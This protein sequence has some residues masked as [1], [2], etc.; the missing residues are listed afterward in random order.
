MKF[1]EAMEI[2]RL[3]F[4]SGNEIPVT[5]ANIT[6]EEY[7]AI[8]EYVRQTASVTQWRAEDFTDDDSNIDC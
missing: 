7:E 3:K 5:M 8:E 1:F 4:S 6:R 2:L